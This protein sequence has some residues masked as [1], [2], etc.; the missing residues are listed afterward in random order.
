MWR[1]IKQGSLII[2]PA[3]LIRVGRL[4]KMYWDYGE[5]LFA[6]LVD[7]SLSKSQYKQPAS[8]DLCNTTSYESWAPVTD[9]SLNTKK[10]YIYIYIYESE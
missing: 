2:M 7:Y 3:Y 4:V 9:G 10:I 8:S 5:R 6:H 1:L